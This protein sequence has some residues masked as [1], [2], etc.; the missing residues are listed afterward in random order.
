VRL[1]KEHLPIVFNGNGYSQEWKE[2][3]ARRGLPDVASTV[4]ALEHYSDPGV[5]NVFMRQGILN[6]REMLARQ[7]ILLETYS[8]TIAIEANTTSR[9]GHTLILPVAWTAQTKAAE[10]VTMTAAVL[11]DDHAAEKNIFSCLR[12][13]ALGLTKA[14]QDLDAARER[15][16]MI[17]ET[18]EQARMARDVLI[19]AMNLCRKHIDAL[20]EKVDNEHWPLPTYAELMWIH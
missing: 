16:G 17:S 2:E 15:L 9:M 8:K 10:L 3:S 7:E 19:P 1:F 12:E 14:L 13:H 11:K 18:L 6:E 5:M 20:E 4:E